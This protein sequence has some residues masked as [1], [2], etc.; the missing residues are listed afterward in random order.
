MSSFAVPEPEDLSCAV[1]TTGGATWVTVGGEIDLATAA[2]FADA[3]R[4]AE[5][6]GDRVLVDL[7]GVEFFASRGAQLLLE[8]ARRVRGQA[9]HFAVK[10]ASDSVIHLLRLMGL[11]DEL[12][13][14]G[15]DTDTA[16]P[17]LHIVRSSVLPH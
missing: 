11:E 12:G 8:S 10:A 7:S 3:L 1:T 17:D 13:C 4:R 14:A 15:A 2:Q 16:R 5:D 9:G 6:L